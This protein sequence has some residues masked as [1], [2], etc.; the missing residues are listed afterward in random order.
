MT[1]SSSF[2]FLL[3]TP[4]PFKEEKQNRGSLLFFS[5]TFLW[6][7]LSSPFSFPFLLYIYIYIYY[8]P[9]LFSLYVFALCYTE[10][11]KTERRRKKE[12]GREMCRERVTKEERYL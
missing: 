2:L 4:R 10:R 1:S 5:K 9:F 11:R 12:L 6:V 7:I 3:L 8:F